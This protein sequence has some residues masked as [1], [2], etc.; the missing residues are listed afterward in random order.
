MNDTDITDTPPVAPANGRRPLRTWLFALLAWTLGP[1]L[2]LG[3]VEAGLRLVGYGRSTQPFLAHTVNG[4]RCASVNQEFFSQF[5]SV[6]PDRVGLEPYDVVIPVE[7]PPNTY[8]VALFGSSAAFGYVHPEYS[9][10]RMLNA[11][12]R[13]QYPG[14]NFEV[15][16]LGA[17]GMNSHVMR[18]MAEAAKPLHFDLYC[19]YMGNNEVK[20]PL[21]GLRDVTGWLPARQVVR[22]YAF[23]SGLRITQ[24]LRR[25]IESVTGQPRN[26]RA[27]SDT[28]GY[29]SMEDPRL[30]RIYRNYRENLESICASARDAGAATVLCTVASNQSTSRPIGSEH[31][32]G[33]TEAESRQWEK[34]YREGISQEEAGQWAR[35]M[36][37]YEQARAIDNGHADLLFRMG[38]CCRALG[39]YDKASEYF[40]RAQ[41]QDFALIIAN[42]SIN[43]TVRDVASARAQDRVYCAD[44]AAQL[45][46]RSPH[47]I[48]GDEFFEDH[49]HL[50]FDGCYELARAVCGRMAPEFPEWVRRRAQGEVPVPSIEACGE[51]MAVTSVD[52]L[53]LIEV[54]LF[55]RC[56]QGDPKPRCD[57][58]EQLRAKYQR[59]LEGRDRNQVTVEACRKAIALNGGDYYIRRKLIR[60][61]AF[62]TEEAEREVRTLAEKCPQFWGTWIL[63]TEILWARGKR[64][65][66][67]A[68]FARLFSDFP[69]YA[70]TW[71]MW[72]NRLADCGRD[73]EALAA[74]RKAAS[75]KR[76]S[77]LP[78]MGEAKLL[79]RLGNADGA[80]RA[81]SEVLVQ[82]P[83]QMEC[84]QFMDEL[85]KTKKSP[86]ERTAL[87]RGL[88]SKLPDAVQPALHLAAA[89]EEGGRLDDASATLLG[90]IFRHPDCAKA[91]EALERCVRKKGIFTAPAQ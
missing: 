88:A 51:H 87:W 91:K 8:R 41:E 43:G 26:P 14:V 6:G 12:L 69:H 77:A 1:L 20:G 31:R 9:P 59:D 40:V 27:W 33:L 52:L 30:K 63:L 28:A 25:A 90:V 13:A 24:A 66:S 81:C 62:G 39:D 72:G 34:Q 48:T 21:A 17:N 53:N 57:H 74:Y 19:V 3:T 68:A 78:K 67:Q 79:L 5:L 38:T 50:T 42:S 49:C 32:P 23:L 58:F 4:K 45:A 85:L 37:N 44:A 15:Y 16:C 61:L 64:E 22:A 83:E 18:L 65:E 10:W 47:G 60:S 56:R 82:D 46:E 73:K 29:T 70:E 35:A 11:M 7:K 2:I 54:P 55:S 36:A 89:Q 86:E 80:V 76:F 84:C 71:Y 75:M